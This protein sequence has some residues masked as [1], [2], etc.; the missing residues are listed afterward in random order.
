MV[1]KGETFDAVYAQSDSMASGA[2]VALK[3]AGI[4]PATIPIVGIDY[5]AEARDAIRAGTQVA[6][7][8]YPTCGKEA[9]D[10]AVRILNGESVQREVEV[11]SVMVTR[12]NVDAVE[13]VF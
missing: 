8:T 3:G 11:P 4:D 5:I 9:A 13:T 2:R 12:D 10:Y 1:E 6:S 7:F